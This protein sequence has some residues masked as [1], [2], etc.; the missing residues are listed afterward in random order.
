MT[1]YGPACAVGKS[2]PRLFIDQFFHHAYTMADE[3]AIKVE[4]PVNDP[5]K[6]DSKEAS[7]SDDKNVEDDEELVDMESLP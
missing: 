4:V 2:L 3:K 6:E 7:P 1:L 5:V